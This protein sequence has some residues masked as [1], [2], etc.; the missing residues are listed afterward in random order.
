MGDVI[1][2]GATIAPHR[3]D[4]ILQAAKGRIIIMLPMPR[5][6]DFEDAAD[7]LAAAADYLQTE[8]NAGRGIYESKWLDAVMHAHGLLLAAADAAPS[9]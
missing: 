1:S 3:P 9:E 6:E 8:L 4:D 2:I 7:R 5:K